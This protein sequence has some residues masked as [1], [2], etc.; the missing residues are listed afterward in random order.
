VLEDIR[1]AFER[2][3]LFQWTRSSN[4]ETMMCLK[5]NF[6]QGAFEIP[7]HSKIGGIL[8]TL[9]QKRTQKETDQV[10]FKNAVTITLP[11]CLKHD[12]EKEGDN[13]CVINKK[14]DLLKSRPPIP[15]GNKQS[16]RNWYPSR[17]GELTRSQSFRKVGMHCLLNLC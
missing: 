4:A 14:R 17:R 1:D 13:S 6:K 16:M 2:M 15:D 8:T 7:Q 5:Y 9:V 11:R 3:E 12:E 10:P